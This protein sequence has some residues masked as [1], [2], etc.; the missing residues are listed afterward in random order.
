MIPAGPTEA[1]VGPQIARRLTGFL[2]DARARGGPLAGLPEAL[3]ARER[4]I[5]EGTLRAAG[6][7][8]REVGET[9]AR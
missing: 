8:P 5:L 9:P 2:R 3:T 7:L 1:G 4:E 6:M